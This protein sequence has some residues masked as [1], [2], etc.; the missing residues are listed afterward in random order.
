[1]ITVRGTDRRRHDRR[2]RQDVWLTFGARNLDLDSDGF[3]SLEHLSENHLP[4]NA[5]SSSQLCHQAEFITYV[6][7][8]ALAHK[9]SSGQAGVILAG[10]FERMTATQ[11][12]RRRE[13][14]ASPTRWA[15][16]FRIRLRPVRHGLTAGHEKRRF[17]RAERRGLLCVVASPDARGGSL[18][19]HQDVLMY[20]ALLAPGQHVI[21][22]LLPGRCAWLHLVVGQA[23]LGDVLLTTGDS[24]KIMA[25]R[26]VSLTAQE[27]TEIILFDLGEPPS[28]PLG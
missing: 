6:R 9:D 11:T 22:K 13:K 19:I 17:S 26:A 20:S 12:V 28:R 8:G 2:N 24:A 18:L 27:E 16:I 3:G 4:P 1:M 23:T 14:N 7:Q 10:E 5:Q 25:E 21:H 15:H